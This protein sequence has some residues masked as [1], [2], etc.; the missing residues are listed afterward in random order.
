MNSPSRVDPMLW[1][2][3]YDS[4]ETVKSSSLDEILCWSARYLLVVPPHGR[5][6]IF[7]Q[8]SFGPQT[9][10]VHTKRVLRG[11]MSNRTS[12]YPLIEFQVSTIIYYYSV[13]S[14]C[15]LSPTRLRS[16]GWFHGKPW[17]LSVPTVL[18]RP[19]APVSGARR[20]A[21]IYCKYVIMWSEGS[22]LNVSG[23]LRACLTAS[24]NVDQPDLI[25]SVR[26]HLC[27]SCDA[28]FTPVYLYIK[29]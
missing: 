25:G 2:L 24:F 28:A 26:R 29:Y 23:W 15:R 11:R 4:P 22:V 9:H 10:S 18:L 19:T 21:S 3:C 27:T 1:L 5:D 20:A 12:Y 6:G 7:V 17:S 14:R 8:A 13:I 16:L